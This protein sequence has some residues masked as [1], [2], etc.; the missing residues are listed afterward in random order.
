MATAIEAFGQLDILIHDAVRVG[1]QTIEEA[2]ASFI[3]RALAINVYTP[4]WLCKQAWKYHK[5]VVPGVVFLV[6]EHC[7]DTGYILRASD[8]QFT[9]TRLT[10]NPGVG[11][12]ID[13]ARIKAGSA[14][15]VA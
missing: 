12:P 11:Y 4:I 2:D 7:H 1:C 9:A 13:L 10:Q 5:W 14:E 8:G 15:Q 6:S 3:G